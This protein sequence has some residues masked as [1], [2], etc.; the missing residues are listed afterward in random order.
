MHKIDSIQKL[1]GSANRGGNFKEESKRNYR[2]QKYCV[3]NKECH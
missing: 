3:R 1:K 2:D